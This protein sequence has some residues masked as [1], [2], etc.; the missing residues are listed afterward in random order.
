M[1]KIVTLRKSLKVPTDLQQMT[2]TYF[3][4][5][6]YWITQEYS[7]QVQYVWCNHILII[8]EYGHSIIISI[9]WHWSELNM[10]HR[11]LPSKSI[12][13]LKAKILTN[14][15][16]LFLDEWRFWSQYSWSS[17]TFSTQS[18]LI[19]RRWCSNFWDH[20]TVVHIYETVCWRRRGW[21]P[22]RP[23]W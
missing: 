23:G 7:T 12:S 1:K 11:H 10:L 4:R 22:W 21:Q 14:H 20:F 2:K 13:T 9:F 6:F 19:L 16:R 18:R 3:G 17:S 8:N 5:Y 15:C